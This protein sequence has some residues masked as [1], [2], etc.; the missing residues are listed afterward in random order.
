MLLRMTPPRLYSAVKLYCEGDQMCMHTKTLHKYRQITTSDEK[1][2]K[3]RNCSPM[4]VRLKIS[5]FWRTR[6]E[7]PANDERQLLWITIW[8]NRTGEA[9]SKLFF[10]RHVMTDLNVRIV[11]ALCCCC[12]CDRCCWCCCEW[13]TTEWK[14]MFAN[15][16]QLGETIPHRSKLLR[17]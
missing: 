13:E 14:M 10:V 1:F 2:S 3:W 7:D 8:V 17:R 15:D 12:C 11:F 4:S 16:G 5:S 9:P 6:A